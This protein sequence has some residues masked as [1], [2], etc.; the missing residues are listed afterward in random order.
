MLIKIISYPILLLFLIINCYILTSIVSNIIYN[1]QNYYWF[2]LGIGSYL[3]FKYLF[4]KNINFIETFVHELTHT[5]VGILFFQKIHS[6]SVNNSEEG[7]VEY[8]GRHVNNVFILLSPYCFPIFSY[9]LLFI[10]FIIAENSLWIYEIVLGFITCFHFITMIKDM[11]P[12]QSD[13]KKSGYLFSYLFILAFL[14]FNIYIVLN[15]VQVSL[16]N[17]F[18]NW[19]NVAYEQ[20]I[21]IIN[22]FMMYHSPIT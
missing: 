21:S 2:A 8:S 15:S 10:K 17:S 1:H 22:C 4:R 11:H 9:F 3:L 16:I 13:I 14:S 5:I 19:C 6:F 18:L 20:T 7:M 12:K